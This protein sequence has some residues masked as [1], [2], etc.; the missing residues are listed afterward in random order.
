MSKRK[1]NI[2]ILTILLLFI[3]SACGTEKK[4]GQEVEE[5]EVS[6]LVIPTAGIDTGVVFGKIISE[7]TG[8]PPQ[9][10]L[11]LSKNITA[12]QTEVPAL[13]SFSYQTNPRAQV[14]EYGYFYFSDIP[15]GVYAIT[16]WTPPN[17]AHFVTDKTEQDYLWVNVTA[18]ETIDLG[19][20]QVP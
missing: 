14:D 17:D 4:T 12:G 3:I 11:F 6:K 10:N 15:V 1:E 5:T 8:M 13:L 19:E 9:A 20:L 7:A 16:L 18:G 2:V